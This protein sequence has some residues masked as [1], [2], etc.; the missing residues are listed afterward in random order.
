MIHDYQTRQRHQLDGLRHRLK[1][2]Q[3]TF[4]GKGVTLYN[5]LPK[6]ITELSEVRFRVCVKRLL[7]ENT[8]YSIEEYITHSF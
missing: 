6:W 5:K 2:T 7:I 3:D 8:F 1:R 4:P